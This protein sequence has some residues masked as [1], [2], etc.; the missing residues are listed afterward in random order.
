MSS[1]GS[2]VS[3]ASPFL[4]GMNQ[5]TFYITFCT[6][7]Q[8]FTPIA[9][10]FATHSPARRPTHFGVLPGADAI[11]EQSPPECP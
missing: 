9:Q 6:V 11:G 7:I 1:V 2:W 5:Y 3:S 10:V 4:I 8:K